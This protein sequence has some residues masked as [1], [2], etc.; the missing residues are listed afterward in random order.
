MD[1]KGISHINIK[2]VN[3]ILDILKDSELSLGKV[4]EATTF[5]D[6]SIVK[7][8]ILTMLKVGILKA[9]EIEDE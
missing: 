4:L 6:I 8:N 2:I 5:D 7:Y 9:R 3:S 1:K